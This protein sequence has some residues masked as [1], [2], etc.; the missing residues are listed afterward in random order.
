MRYNEWDIEEKRMI[1]A[2]KKLIRKARKGCQESADLLRDMYHLKVYTDDDIEE[3]N[4]FMQILDDAGI[5]YEDRDLF[6]GS[7]VRK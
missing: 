2:R 3:L 6:E 4:N 1:S 7:G 5:E